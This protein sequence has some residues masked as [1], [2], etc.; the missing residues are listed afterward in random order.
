MHAGLETW[1]DLSRSPG[2]VRLSVCVSLSSCFILADMHVCVFIHNAVTTVSAC[3]VF[4]YIR[5]LWSLPKVVSAWV[6]RSIKPVQKKPRR[7]A[8]VNWEHS[9]YQ[10]KQWL[11]NYWVLPVPSAICPRPNGLF[12][13][14]K[15]SVRQRNDFTFFEVK[16][17][18]KAF[19]LKTQFVKNKL[20]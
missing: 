15:G 16:K 7:G 3:C 12:F 13:S 19:L 17:Q 5:S 9:A 18:N 20:H 2:H 4:I 6:R 1:V 10:R 8:E 14:L 11:L